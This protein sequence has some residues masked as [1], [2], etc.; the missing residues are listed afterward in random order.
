MHARRAKRAIADVSLGQPHPPSRQSRMVRALFHGR[1]RFCLTG[2]STQPQPRLHHSNQ[3]ITEKNMCD[4]VSVNKSLFGNERE[5]PS[6][7]SLLARRPA[8][9]W[10]GQHK[11]Q[12]SRQPHKC[13]LL[14]VA[15]RLYVPSSRL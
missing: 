15:G 12:P 2:N 13:G 1:A 11:Y 10:A 3:F 7:R 5:T 14:L 8:I 4:D 6:I 9:A